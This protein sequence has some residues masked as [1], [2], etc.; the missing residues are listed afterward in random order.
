MEFT[1]Q[2][3]SKLLTF[4]LRKL[5]TSLLI[6]NFSECRCAQ[7]RRAKIMELRHAKNL[8]LKL[9]GAWF[10]MSYQ[11]QSQ[12]GREISN[13]CSILMSCSSKDYLLIRG[14]IRHTSEGF[15]WI[16]KSVQYPPTG[17]VM[18]PNLLLSS[19][20]HLMVKTSKV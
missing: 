5:F 10:W 11:F 18:F 20:C 2:V 13:S 17:P 16:H 8:A 7:K 15:D 9:M 4:S 3:R 6:L 1:F 19:I 14:G 12:M